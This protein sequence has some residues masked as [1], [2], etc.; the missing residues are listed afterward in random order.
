MKYAKLTDLIGQGL[1]LLTTLL[2]LLFDSE[3]QN[4]FFV[5]YFVLGGWQFLSFLIHLFVDP[6]SGYHE[7]KRMLYGKALLWAMVGLVVSFILSYSGFPL[8]FYY[9]FALLFVTPFYALAYLII[10]YR[11]IQSITRKELIHLKN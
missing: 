11:E 3:K 2:L 1:L 5:F 10:S 4:A 9:L 7:K 8:L 6:D